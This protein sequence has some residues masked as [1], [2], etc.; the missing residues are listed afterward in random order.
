MKAADVQTPLPVRLAHAIRRFRADYVWD[1]NEA[2]A[3]LGCDAHQ[4]HRA[5]QALEPA[6]RFCPGKGFPT[7]FGRAATIAKIKARF[8]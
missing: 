6:V 7:Y 4:L 3:A 5:T 2:C 1:T 8:R